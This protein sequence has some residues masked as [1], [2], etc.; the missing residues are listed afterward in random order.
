[1]N[2]RSDKGTDKFHDKGTNNPN[3]SVSFSDKQDTCIIQN[4]H[5]LGLY[6]YLIWYNKYDLLR[7]HKSLYMEVRMIQTVYPGWPQYRCVKQAA[8]GNATELCIVQPLVNEIVNSI[9][10]KIDLE[11]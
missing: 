3:K 2:K 6:R 5:D 7:I 1:M 10:Q 8:L 9:F 11:M 4:N